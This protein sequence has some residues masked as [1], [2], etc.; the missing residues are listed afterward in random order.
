M[1]NHNLIIIDQDGKAI[2]SL[3]QNRYALVLSDFDSEDHP[4]VAKLVAIKMRDD[5]RDSQRII[6]V[7]YVLEE[8][9]E[10]ITSLISS[11]KNKEQLFDVREY[12]SNT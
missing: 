1:A 6:S 12:N 5:K 2:N 3:E 9:T 10:A 4:I 7:F 8:A 11:I